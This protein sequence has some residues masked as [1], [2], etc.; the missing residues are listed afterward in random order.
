MLRQAR[1]AIDDGIDA[2]EEQPPDMGQATAR[3]GT[4]HHN[5]R[6]E[7]IRYTSAQLMFGFALSFEETRP[8][9][10]ILHGTINKI[11]P[12]EVALSWQ[13]AS[14]A[15]HL[16]KLLTVPM[17]DSLQRAM[18][19]LEYWVIS[20]AV[21]NALSKYRLCWEPSVMRPSSSPRGSEL[22]LAGKED[23]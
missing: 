5:P 7:Y 18:K 22:A 4:K 10:S 14:I 16:T 2:E 8:L 1:Q 20:G 21:Q 17:G 3:S 9:D 12:E 6:L 11:S 13:F 23:H 15:K 19:W